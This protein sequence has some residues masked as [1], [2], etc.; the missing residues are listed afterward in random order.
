MR[1]DRYG[2]KTQGEPGPAEIFWHRKTDLSFSLSFSN[3]NVRN[4]KK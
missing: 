4:K 3:I 1:S 2:D